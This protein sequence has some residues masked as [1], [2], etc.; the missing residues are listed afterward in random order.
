FISTLCKV[1]SLASVL[2]VMDMYAPVFR[3]ACPEPSEELVNLPR[4]LTTINIHLQFYATLDVLQSVITH[5]PMFFRY[6]LDILSPRD[7]ELLHAEDGPGLRWLYGVPDRLMI[8][9][10]RINTFLEDFGSCVDAGGIRELEKEI[11]SFAPVV[12]PSLRTDPILNIARVA[13]QESWRLAAYVYLH[14]ALCGADS[15]DAR[16]VKTQQKFMRLLETI[17]PR[18]NPDLFL[19]LPMLI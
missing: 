16:V 7:E 2:N 17:Q 10:A 19:V 12:C 8:T 15:S 4:V 13:V 6:N 1:G 18:R 5:R 3:R 9:F 11:A 14:M